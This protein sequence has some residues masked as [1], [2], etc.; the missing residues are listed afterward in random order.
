MLSKG[1]SPLVRMQS[2]LCVNAEE[3]TVK[4]VEQLTLSGTRRLRTLG[5]EPRF[6]CLL[7][8]K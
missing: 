5:L 7:E 3:L 2:S 6:Y 4:E 1:D 8:P